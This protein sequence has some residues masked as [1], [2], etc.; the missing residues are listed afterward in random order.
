MAK[1][2]NKLIEGWYQKNNQKRYFLRYDQFGMIIYQTESQYQKYICD[3]K[4]GIKNLKTSQSHPA[5]D[6]WWI[7]SSYMMPTNNIYPLQLTLF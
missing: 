2:S 4:Y 1:S 5:F 7:G 3:R 6:K